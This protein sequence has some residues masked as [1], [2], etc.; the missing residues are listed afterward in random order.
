M[1]VGGPVSYLIYP[2]NEE[3]LLKTIRILKDEGIGYRFVGNATNIIVDDRG[4]AEAVIRITRMRSSQQKKVKDGAFV[5]VSGG[6][7]LKGFIRNNAEKGLSGLEKLYWIPGTVGGAVKMNAGSFGASISDALEKLRIVNENGEMESYSKNNMAFSYR[8]SSVRPFDCIVSAAFYMKNRDKSE[9][10]ADMDYVYTERKKRH[11]ME[12]PSSGSIFKSV[13]GESAWQYVEKAGLRGFRIGDACVSE[14]HTNFI[15]NTGHATAK[16]I[17]LLIDTIKKEVFEKIG[18]LLEE[19][20][21]LWGF[22]E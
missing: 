17:K 9:I 20:V 3:D 6:V 21:E 8:A 11:P 13:D 18:V 14:K 7:S 10:A 5:E 12:Y 22:E 4:L 15:V 2:V 1:R 16:D 19:E